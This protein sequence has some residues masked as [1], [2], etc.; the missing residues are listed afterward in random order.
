[1]LKILQ[2]AVSC[3][4]VS[5][6]FICFVN[7][8][9]VTLC[10]TQMNMF[11]QLKWSPQEGPFG[12]SPRWSLMQQW[13]YYCSLIVLN[14]SV[15]DCIVFNDI[16]LILVFPHMKYE[17]EDYS[18]IWFEQHMMLPH[19]LLSSV[20]HHFITPVVQVIRLEVLHHV[21]QCSSF[22]SWDHEWVGSSGCPGLHDTWLWLCRCII[23]NIW[24][25]GS[26]TGACWQQLPFCI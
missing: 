4:K 14:F 13:I 19:S 9:A 26:L 8:H 2:K 5:S 17:A 21:I 23:C 18:L 6:I 11:L 20:I 1:M 22:S 12:L 10:T 15:T 24:S 7:K 3:V 25:A 16:F